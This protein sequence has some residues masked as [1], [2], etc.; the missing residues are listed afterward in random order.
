MRRPMAHPGHRRV[1]QWVRG[2][3]H[4]LP[5]KAR[6]LQPPV[7]H[8]ARHL[9]LPAGREPSPSGIPQR[10]MKGP[11]GWEPTTGFPPRRAL[12]PTPAPVPLFRV[13]GGCL[14][15]HTSVKHGEAPH[16]PGVRPQP[17]FHVNSGGDLLSHTLPS[18]VPSALWVLATGFGMGPGVSPTL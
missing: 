10:M 5:R 1:C 15:E 8:P 3:I 13:L 16:H 9:N 4:E 7:A 11:A 18:A 2:N 17:I 14:V 6:R 12:P